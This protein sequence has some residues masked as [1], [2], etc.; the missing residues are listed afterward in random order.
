MSNSWVAHLIWGALLSLIPIVYIG[1]KYLSHPNLAE[2]LVPFEY[3]LHLIIVTALLNLGLNL[4]LVPLLKESDYASYSNWIL[5]AIV[6]VFFA[7]YIKNM[8]VPEISKTLWNLKKPQNIYAYS[9]FYWS[10]IYALLLPFLQRQ[11]CFH[12]PRGY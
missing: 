7:I 3:F 10:I 8:W 12:G 2:E 11:V 9:V 1:I 4:F 6:G 5:G